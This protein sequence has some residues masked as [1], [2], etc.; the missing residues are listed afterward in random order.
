VLYIYSTTVSG[1]AN[2]EAMSDRQ[3]YEERE[4]W[5]N[6][7]DEKH[8]QKF[9]DHVMRIAAQGEDIVIPVYIDSYGGYVD[10][11]A[12]MIET[13][14]NVPNRFITI[15]MGK[16]MSCGAILLSHGDIRYCGKF[17]RVMIHNV[18]AGSWGEAYELKSTSDETL[19]M[20]RLFMELLANNCG[21]SYQEVQD[22][23]RATTSGKEIWMN[24]D[25]AFKFGIVDHIGTP[26][27]TPVIQFALNTVPEKQRLTEEEKGV[28]KKRTTT[29]KTTKKVSKKKT[30]RKTK[31]K[32]SSDASK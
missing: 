6:H 30:A 25:D 8:A 13:M 22:A 24:G 18:H 4:I 21:K 10:S 1:E 5:V 19:R 9:R 14:D 2:G 17:S 31:T 20:N 28:K 26:L 23:I 29:K 16:A 11:L 32:G 7:F 27:I 12:K 15:C 3:H